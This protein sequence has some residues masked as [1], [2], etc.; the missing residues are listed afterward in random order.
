MSEM[1][2]RLH[3][4]AQGALGLFDSGVGGLSVVRA[5]LEALPH[6]AIRYVADSANCPYGSRSADEIRALSEGISRYLIDAGCK[7]IVVACNTASA[8]AL[9]HLR[10]TFP[11]T[12]FVGMVP[13]VKPA[14]QLTRTGVVGVLATPVT[15]RGALYEEVVS[16]YGRS[17]RVLSRACPGLVERI[18]AGDLESPAVEALLRDCVDPMLAAGADTLVLGCTHYPFIAPTLQRLVGDDVQIVEP[19][20]AIARQ[21]ARVLERNGL[22]QTRR[23]PPTRLYLTTGAVAPFAAVLSRL[24]GAAAVGEVGALG[25]REGTLVEPRSGRSPDHPAA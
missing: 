10:R 6:E 11:Q 16:H 13:A 4:R 9:E 23:E 20:A 24:V 14:A 21:A 15:F 12:P 25:W 5:L 22:L 18:E 3:E 1:D 8:A 19:S 17:L 7:L 2:A